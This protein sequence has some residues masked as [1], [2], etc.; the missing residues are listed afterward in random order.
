[1]Q[2]LKIILSRLKNPSV[3][4]SIASQIL[5]V[6]LLFHVKI[7]ILDMNILTGTITAISSIL[8]L[9]GITSDPTTKNKGY[10]DDILICANCQRKTIH[11]QIN[12]K[13]VCEKC[14]TP[15]K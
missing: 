10:K 12:D 6:L 5:T 2:Q 1:M 14:G 15:H 7:G 9:L 13:M 3:V 8:V 11:R 4:I